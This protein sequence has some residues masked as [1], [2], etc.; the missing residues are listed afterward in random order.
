MPKVS[1]HSVV[2]KQKMCYHHGFICKKIRSKRALSQKC[3]LERARDMEKSIRQEIKIPREEM[4][5][6]FIQEFKK[7][8]LRGN[9]ID[10]AI[11]VV[12]GAAFSKVVSSLVN[13]IIM[14]II[15]VVL[16]GVDF[17]DLAVKLPSTKADAPEVLVKYGSFI[18]TLVDFGIVAFVIFVVIKVINR[19]L[20]NSVD[21]GQTTE[22]PAC[23]MLIPVKAKKCGHCQTML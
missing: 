12:I 17:N 13:D 1:I 5:M 7:F 23:A 15:G 10:L 16:S 9:L 3:E 21:Q 19:L 2:S 22:C 4:H 14:P 18:N 6:S 20:P 11:G 8:A